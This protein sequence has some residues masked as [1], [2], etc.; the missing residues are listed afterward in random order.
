MS[1]AMKIKCCLATF[2][3]NKRT[4]SNNKTIGE[5][6]MLVILTFFKKRIQ[7]SAVQRSIAH[8]EA[9]F[10][11]V[12][13]QVFGLNCNIL[14][15]FLSKKAVLKNFHGTSKAQAKVLVICKFV[16]VIYQRNTED[17]HKIVKKCTCIEFELEFGAIKHQNI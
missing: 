11:S 2:D 12:G 8:A 4:R 10:H 14:V 7:K 5:K 15:L 13:Q 6:K 3:N 9:F 17:S 16:N 1:P